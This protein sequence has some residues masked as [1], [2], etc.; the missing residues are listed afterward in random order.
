M[1]RR[2]H[3]SSLGGL[4]RLPGGC[5]E[6]RSSHDRA[7]GGTATAGASDGGASP[8]F[9]FSGRWV[10]AAQQAGCRMAATP[11]G[12]GT[13]VARRASSP[14]ATRLPRVDGQHRITN[15]RLHGA[16]PNG[17]ATVW[18]PT[19]ASSP[20]QRRTSAP[21][22]LA[23][24]AP[25]SIAPTATA[26]ATISSPVGPRVPVRRPLLRRLSAPCPAIAAAS[27]V[28]TSAAPDLSPQTVLQRLVYRT[29]CDFS[30]LSAT[31]R[32]SGWDGGGLLRPP[33]RTTDAVR[34]P[35]VAFA[36]SDS[37]LWAPTTAPRL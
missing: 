22:G 36:A 23:S 29:T 28:S 6:H 20:R 8:R 15:P 18:S 5:A 14:S 7:Q 9:P 27:K 13:A 26:A 19:A 37:S 11:S 24:P 31:I 21:C 4:P 34:V 16:T 17:G 3:F 2:R 1:L 12:N 33:C 10:G 30:A 25:R 32:T 35:L